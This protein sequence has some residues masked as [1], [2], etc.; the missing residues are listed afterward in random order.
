LFITADQVEVVADKEKSCEKEADF[1]KEFDL[2]IA[3]A[4]SKVGTSAQCCGSRFSDPG[5]QTHIFENL[6]TIFWVK[7]SI[8]HFVKFVATKRDNKFFSPLSFVAVFES[9][10]RNG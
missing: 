6:V 7:S 10:I 2:V 3:T 4:C 1:F 8:F 5:F 9:G